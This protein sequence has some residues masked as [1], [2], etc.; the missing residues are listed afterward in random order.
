MAAAA[1][2]ITCNDVPA[3]ALPVLQAQLEAFGARVTIAEPQAGTVS[4]TI[5]HMAGRMEFKHADSVLLIV[6]TADAG[7]F[8]R[9]LL[10][11][12]VKQM[13]QEAAETVRRSQ[14]A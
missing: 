9:S 8:A 7:H 12:G 10:I 11:G 1:L 5:E 2:S 4:G 3:T 6:L 13:V 14:G